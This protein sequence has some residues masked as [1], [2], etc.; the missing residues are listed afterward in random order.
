M[1][2]VAN[3]GLVRVVVPTTRQ[4]DI[5]VHASTPCAVV[6]FRA[7]SHMLCLILLRYP[8]NAVMHGVEF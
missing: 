1:Q 2:C 8:C 5:T 7:S 6:C 3:D 4:R